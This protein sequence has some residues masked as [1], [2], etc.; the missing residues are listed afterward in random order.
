MERNLLP[1]FQNKVKL[2]F[3]ELREADAAV[4]GDSALVWEAKTDKVA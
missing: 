2:L 1:I 3:S 4:L